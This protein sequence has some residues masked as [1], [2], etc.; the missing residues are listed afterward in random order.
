MKLKSIAKT[1]LTLA[2]AV[3]AHLSTAQNLT[4][5]DIEA[6]AGKQATLAVSLSGA[7]AMTALQFNLTLPEGV[8][9]ADGDMPFG[10]A[11]AD[12]TLHV[13]PLVNGD[14]MFVV[15]SMSLDTFTDG[16]LL[17]IPVTIG[18]DA[19]TGEGS[20]SIVRMS[21]TEAVSQT[22][23]NVAFT[24]TVTSSVM[25]GDINGDGKV[26]VSDY[27]GIA[28]HILGATSENFNED[29]AD[30]NGDGV[31]DVSDY[32]GIANIILSSNVNG[33]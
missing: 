32:I 2:F 17:Q 8:T 29:A 26:D 5:Q 25:S 27:I 19:T 3:V 9:I 21:T 31:I 18:N 7:S 6:E 12:H 4:V 23:D 11:V 13:Q 33:K 28:N 15:Y 22:C 20:L 14:R 16:E 24:V 1:L 10:S 30:V